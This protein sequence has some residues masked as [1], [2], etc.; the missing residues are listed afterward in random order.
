MARASVV[1]LQALDDLQM[2]A[3][4]ESTVDSGNDRSCN[5]QIS[6]QI[7][8]AGRDGFGSVGGQIY[9][10]IVIRKWRG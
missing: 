6:I 10:E 5:E 4:L 2:P 1:S 8:D 7:G 3:H 9:P